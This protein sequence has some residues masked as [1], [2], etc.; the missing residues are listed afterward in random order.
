MATLV[1]VTVAIRVQFAGEFFGKLERS[2][3]SPQERDE[4]FCQFGRSEVVR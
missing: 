4:T 1:P 2:Y 3:Q